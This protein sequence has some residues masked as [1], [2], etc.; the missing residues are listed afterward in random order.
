MAINSK[1]IYVAIIG[2]IIDSKKINNR[3]EVQ[4]KLKRVLLEI[5]QSYDE[6]IAANFMISLGDEFQGLICK[7]EKVFDIINDIEMNMFPVKIRFGIG[8]GKIDT[9]IFK[10]NTLEIAGPAYYNARK[11]ISILNE[12]KKSYEK[13][14][15]NIIIDSGDKLR[16][17]DE[18]INSILSL[19]YISKSKWKQNS[20]NVIK[21]YLKNNCNQ[22]AV[23]KDLG[24]Q[25]PAISKTLNNSNFYTI[26]HSY[27]VLKNTMKERDDNGINI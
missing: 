24:V 5:N 8:V 19:I 27:N 16:T 18:L 26:N 9:D 1:N 17:Q 25:Q 7:Q 10:N 4:Q 2:D 21:S 20:I 22:Y 3:N 13:I 15:T 23:A 6:I 14:A 11:S 12:R